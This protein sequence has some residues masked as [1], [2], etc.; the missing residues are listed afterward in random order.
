MKTA[1]EPVE[2][3]VATIFIP[4]IALF[5]IPVT[6]IRPLIELKN[7]TQFLK[8]SSMYLDKFLIELL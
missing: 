4:I 3:N 1:G 2:F 6:I 7:S 8:S 5:P